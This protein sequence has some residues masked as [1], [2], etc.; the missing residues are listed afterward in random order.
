[1]EIR[2]NS[3]LTEAEF[4]KSYDS[5]KYEKPSVTVDMLLFTLEEKKSDDEKK[6]PEKELKVLL[7]KRKD[8]PFIGHWAI[9]GGFVSVKESLNNAVY[10]ELREETNIE[11]VYLEQL[12]T[13]GEVERDPRMRV[14]STSY[15]ALI[16]REGL[17]EKAGDD[18]E[19]LAWFTIKKELIEECLVNDEK[20][21]RKYIL[22]I[23]NKEKDVKII[24]DVTENRNVRGFNQEV[25]YEFS[26]KKSSNMKL[27][28]DH[29]EIINYA[30]NRMANKVEY[31]TIAFSLLPELFTLTELQ[32]VY[33][34]LLGR[35]L[36]KPNFRRWIAK[37]VEE[38]E[39][40][41]R[42]GSFRPA[43]LYKINTRNLL[44]GI[45][46]I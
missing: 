36:T 38:T 43:K 12:Y 35:E 27:A 29:I 3:G 25:N 15:M 42:E 11:N 46:N 21:V 16:N 30:L 45:R 40:T 22:Y 31:T 20:L 14:I 5:N 28:F 39:Y 17:K 41:K 26:L 23:E 24:Y 44:K 13:F 33:E 1:M 7:I 19:D 9:P 2:N 34:L 32:Q 6:L 4:L 37:L 10:R 8:H 18:A